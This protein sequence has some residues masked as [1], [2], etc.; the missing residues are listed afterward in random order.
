MTITVPP[1][2]PIAAGG[3]IEPS[4][5]IH[6]PPS[7]LRRH[8]YGIATL[9][10]LLN[11]VA[12][13]AGVN[14]ARYP[15]RFED[16]GTYIAQ[17]WAMQYRNSIAHYTYWYDHPFLGWSQIAGWDTLTNALGRYGTSVAAGREFMLVVTVA[18]SGILY[19]IARRLGMHRPFAV[20]AVLLF[21]LCP[22]ALTFHRFVLLDNV[23]VMWVLAAFALALTPRK[24]IGAVAC[25]GACM[26]IAI[27]S[28]E[29]TAILLPALVYQLLQ[30]SDRRNR[31]YS[32]AVFS[33]ILLMLTAVYVLYA[34]LKSE[35][36]PGNGHVSL[37]GTLVWQLHD[38]ASSGSILT[39][40]SGAQG[41]TSLWLGLDP[42]LL[43]LAA[44]LM[45]LGLYYRRLRPITVALA[46]QVLMLLRPGYL[47][48][49]YVISMLPFAA[50]IIVG[51]GHTTWTTRPR[52]RQ[53]IWR[54]RIRR[55]LVVAA[56]LAVIGLI[57]EP[58]SN[59]LT[60]AFTTDADEPSRQAVNW[61][62]A[63]ASKNDRLVVDS[64]LWLDLVRQGFDSPE[65]VWLYKTETDPAV[66]KQLGGWNGIDYIAVTTATLSPVN[67]DTFPTLFE[68]KQHA[69]PVAIFGT[70]S[71]EITILKVNHEG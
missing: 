59:K 66:T 7:W 8:A 20:A 39:P 70:G 41:L 65:A 52:V 48:F 50:L 33:V 1:N 2:P 31:R 47:P 34:A 10:V 9:V 26:A 35:L 27:L 44:L 15:L 5:E 45:P 4:P 51:V 3:Q 28:K 53:S 37:I 19:V 38:R 16:E 42:W 60:A 14:M 61:V 17:A 29:T 58:W 23:A 62:A 49:P 64:G 24:H 56:T 30:N 54:R 32:L 63:N 43:G 46:L 12:L 6:K 69:V 55:G 11:I 18:S 25:S 36:F 13:V 68:A 57:A 40:G 21:V 67:Q 22:L 71:S